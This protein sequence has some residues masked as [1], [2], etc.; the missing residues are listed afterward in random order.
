M[1]VFISRSRLSSYWK[2]EKMS[3]LIIAKLARDIF[4]DA[5]DKSGNEYEELLF[6]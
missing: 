4:K 2:W 5:E 3:V 6:K 1:C